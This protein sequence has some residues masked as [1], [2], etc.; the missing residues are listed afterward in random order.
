MD[1]ATAAHE[2]EPGSSII[3]LSVPHEVTAKTPVYTHN[4]QD[5][6]TLVLQEEHGCTLPYQFPA[7]RMFKLAE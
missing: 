2:A 1:H 4:G 5:L 3:W 6:V 7:E